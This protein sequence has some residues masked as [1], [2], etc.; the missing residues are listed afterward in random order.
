MVCPREP[1]HF[2]GEGFCAEVSHVPERDGQID[3]PEGERLDS[4]YDPVEWRRRPG[5]PEL[6]GTRPVRPVPGGTGP[7]RYTNRSGA[8]SQ[9]VPV[10]FYPYRTG[11]FHRFTGR[12]FYS[13]E[14][15]W[16]SVDGE[17][18]ST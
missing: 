1:H 12:F 4:R 10:I 7:A 5:F 2:E 14:P 3:L 13:W 17:N 16:G 6:L 18:P 15:V 9:T 11:R 8:Q